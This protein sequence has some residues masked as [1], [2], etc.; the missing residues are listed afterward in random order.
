MGGKWA[1]SED[2]HSWSGPGFLGACPPL[3]PAVRQT[4]V[5]GFAVRQMP[6]PGLC[7]R[8]SGSGSV[9]EM[10]VPGS[11]PLSLVHPFLLVHPTRELLPCDVLS[12]KK[13]SQD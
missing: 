6:V 7:P 1:E 5:P 3:P 4:P 11:V 12:R 13:P 9:R 8:L 2:R 10:P